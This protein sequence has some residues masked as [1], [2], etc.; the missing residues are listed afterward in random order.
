MR[1]WILPVNPIQ[2]DVEDARMAKL[3]SGERP[4]PMIE[5]AFSER[6]SHFSIKKSHESVKNLEAY[7][8]DCVDE[9]G[10]SIA[11]HE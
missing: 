7:I 9:S 8:S 3:I 6:Y 2:D 11:T 4:S 10:S 5:S 1:N